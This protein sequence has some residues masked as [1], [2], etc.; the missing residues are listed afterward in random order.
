MRLALAGRIAD[1]SA[2]REAER[3]GAL[4]LHDLDDAAFEG[5]IVA[6][7][8]ILCLR[9]G[10]VG[11]TNGPLL[12][13]LGAGRA[14]LATPTGSI[15][16]V[17]GD[18]VQYCDGTEAGIRQG[19]LELA[20]SEARVELERAARRRAAGSP[21]TGRP[22]CTRSSSARCSM[23]SPEAGLTVVVC[24]H[25]RP[26]RPRTVPRGARRVSTTRPR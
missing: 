9:A 8:C 18:A 14:V 17:A 22:P 7:D 12:D 13:A 25:N 15:P 5:A 11:E 26:A 20:N 21:G 24:T 6:A 2:A 1:R 3:R 19:L 4:V 10:S 16:E 23:P